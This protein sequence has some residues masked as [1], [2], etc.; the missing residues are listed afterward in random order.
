MPEVLTTLEYILAPQQGIA[1]A[2]RFPPEIIL[3]LVITQGLMTTG[4]T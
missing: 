3:A 1:G 4:W 2:L